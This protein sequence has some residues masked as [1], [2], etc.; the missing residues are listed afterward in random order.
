VEKAQLAI[1]G[2]CQHLAQLKKEVSEALDSGDPAARRKSTTSGTAGK[3]VSEM[4]LAAGLS[5]R[6]QQFVVDETVL[7]GGYAAAIS[8]GPTTS[9][10]GALPIL[11]TDCQK[12]SQT[13][14][15]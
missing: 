15:K 6:Y 2:G 4:G 3:A 8:G 5:G 12:V 10:T 14:R 1:E 7:N 11:S 9:L 13:A